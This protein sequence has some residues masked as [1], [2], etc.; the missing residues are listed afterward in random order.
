MK[1][2][3]FN[4]V[5]S[6]CANP[7]TRRGAERATKVVKRLSRQLSVISSVEAWRPDEYLQ[8][9]DDTYVPKTLFQDFA[10]RSLPGAFFHH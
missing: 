1:T 2:M 5:A 4:K 9:K 3:R 10:S 6:A 8:G 7:K